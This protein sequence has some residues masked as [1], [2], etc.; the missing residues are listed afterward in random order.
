MH[1]NA[2][3]CNGCDIELLAALMPRFDLE[4]FG[5]INTGNPKHADILI[6]TGGVNAQCRTVLENLYHELPEPKVV[7]AAGTCATS[8]GIFRGAPN[9]VGS[10]DRVIP[11]DLYV[12]G[13]AV[14]PEA[15]I[16]GV[17]QALA[18][19]EEKRARMAAFRT[20]AGR[21]SLH[22]AAVED[23]AEILALQKIVYRAMAELYN[24]PTLSPL[25]QTL[26]ELQ[27][28][29]ARYRFIKAVMDGKII[30]AIRGRRDAEQDTGY[31]GRLTTHPYYQGRGIGRTLLAAMEEKLGPVARYELFTG[32][33]NTDALAF[34][35]RHGYTVA[36]HETVTERRQRVYLEKKTCSRS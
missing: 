35:T 36:R 6:V 29:F 9:I 15:L 4:R 19:L 32:Q 5:I 28:D 16:D 17:V 11:V 33:K 8:C 23:A 27:A 25:R 14:R 3:S 30:G 7:M 34:Y 2:A 22:E 13:C 31:I 21:V 26:P 12:P 10:V 20:G 18:V 24:D 1:Y